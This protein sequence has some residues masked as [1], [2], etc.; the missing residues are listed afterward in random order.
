MTAKNRIR[1]ANILAV[2]DK[3]ANLIALE[4]VLRDDFNVITAESGQAAI[5]ILLQRQDIDVI[6]MDIQMPVMD[7]YE[8]SR[9]IKS[10]HGCHDIPIIFITAVYKE[11]PFVRQGYDAGAVDYFSKP[12][13][14]EILKKKVSIYAS[15]RLKADL[16]RERER[17][18]IEAEELLKAGRK[19]SSVLESLPVG[20]L[21]VDKNGDVC[22]I[23]EAVSK[24]IKSVGMAEADAYG[25]ILRWWDS[26]GKML[27]NY[28]GPLARAVHYG[29]TSHNEVIEIRCVDGTKK[30]I[31]GSAAPLYDLAHEIMGAVVIIQDVTESKLIEADLENRITKL[32]AIGVEL[33]Q[34]M[35]A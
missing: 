24:I 22:Q 18:I 31:L 11:E 10:L 21:I 17:Q 23:N 25:G 1:K 27:K 35:R 6:L 14:P 13:D 7:G 33:E 5:S 28:R 20:V 15:F 8:A 9:K 3:P 26:S 4:A 2:D 12:F 32:V 34:T 30:T 19:L 16:L 29:E